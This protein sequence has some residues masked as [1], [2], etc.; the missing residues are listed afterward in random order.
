MKLSELLKFD[1]IAI[2]CHDFPDA[3]AIASGFG[4]YHY[5]KAHGK[6]PLLFYSGRSKISKPNMLLMLN[7]LG[8]PVQ[9]LTAL[10]HEPELLVTV[11]CAYGE[12]N[13]QR[14]PAKNVAVIDHHICRGTLP[15][16]NEVRSSYGS[17]ASIIRQMLLD[18]GID[19]N[20][21]KRLATALYYGLYMDTNGFA[22]IRHSA[23]KDLRDLTDFDE[24]LMLLLKNSNLSSE[25][26]I[27]AG[28]A[29][30]NCRYISEYDL[31][32][33]RTAP[34]DPN[35][36][37]FIS[38]IIIQVNTVGSC[39]VFCPTPAGYKMSVRSCSIETNAAD[40]AKYIA[41]GDG[42]GHAQK[43]GGFI[44]NYILENRDISDF[45]TDRMISYHRDADVLHAGTDHADTS[46]M[47]RYRKRDNILGYIPSTELFD[48][49]KELLIR[50][51]EADTVLT[52]QHD[53]Y[54]M[55]GV[56]GEVYPISKAVFEKR[57]KP[58]GELPD[59]NYDYIPAVI[60]KVKKESIPLTRN[61]RGCRAA[62]SSEIAAKQLTK[63]TKVFTQWN[64]SGF[65]Y[66]EP[67]DYLAAR[68]DDDTDFYIIKKDIFDKLYDA[69]GFE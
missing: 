2:Q 22:E 16:M 40:L 36:L 4:V 29:L 49:G 53:L 33:T 69:A 25:E 67:G 51:P 55:V 66:G 23:D 50:M 8:I 63:H 46:G 59:M 14:F 3:D 38:D 34:C 68:I 43:A 18:E 13:V 28:D 24:A 61:I 10:G 58:C 56:A 7:N 64:Q 37:G 45:I 1:D 44:S 21:D 52:A 41:D 42:G 6:E 62:D 12:S 54:I 26:M 27:I 47:S 35:I 5:L 20:A 48:E 17:C 32:L 11:D 15:E 65:L 57:Y 30:K 9:Y 19:P 39:V 31:A 60:D